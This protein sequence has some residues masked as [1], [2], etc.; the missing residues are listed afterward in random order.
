MLKWKGPIEGGITQSLINKF[1]VCPYQFY[2]YA[3]LGLKENKPDNNNLMWGDIFHKALELAIEHPRQIKGMIDEELLEIENKVKQHISDKWPKSPST[4]LRSVMNML[5]LYNDSYKADM[6]G[7]VTEKEFVVPY[8]N[9]HGL[10]V[11]LRGKRDGWHEGTKTL[12]EHKCKGRI[13]KETTTQEIPM[14]QQVCLYSMV[15]GAKNIIYDL[16]L[17]PEAQYGLPQMRPGQKL[18]NFV[19]SWFSIHTGPPTST[20]WPIN[21]KTPY[22]FAQIHIPIT[23]ENIE[24]YRKFTLDPLIDRIYRWWNHVNKPGFDFQNPDHYNDVFYRTPIRQFNPHATAGYKG[25]YHDFLTG[26]LALEDLVP[27]ESFYA[28]LTE[29]E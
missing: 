6:P 8:T 15:S 28:E 27:V 29:R 23:E 5:R 16:I 19:D 3:G 2:I 14:D 22:W 7:I 11:N 12:I 26:E 20:L 4:Y 24:T 10:K 1:L 21:K 9:H 17:I 18:S 25:E 13:D